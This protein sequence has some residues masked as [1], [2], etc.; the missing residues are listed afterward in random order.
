M[1]KRDSEKPAQTK[2]QP[3][4]TPIDRRDFIKG[5]AI[6]LA[7]V[8][9][10][11]AALFAGDAKA[12]SLSA[13][14]T[15]TE[16]DVYYRDRLPDNQTPFENPIDDAVSL[17]DWDFPK[18]VKSA[19]GDGTFG[20]EGMPASFSTFT[21][22]PDYYRGMPIAI[23][24][25]G[26]AG[27]AAGYELMKLGF[28]PVF[29]EMQTQDSPDGTTYAR[30]FGRIYSWDFGGNGQYDGAGAGWYPTYGDDVASQALNPQ[31]GLNMHPW[32][33]RVAELGGMRFPATHLT[34]RTYTDD[35]FNDDYRYGPE[36]LVSPWVAFRDPGLYVPINPPNPHRG[37]VVPPSD[38]DLLDYDTVYNTKGIFADRTSPNPPEPGGYSQTDRVR[39]GTTL[40]S[41]NAAVRNLTFKYYNLLYGDPDPGDPYQGVLTPILTLYSAY[42][43]DQS[44][45]IADQIVQ[46]WKSLIDK[47]DNKSLREVLSEAGWDDLPAYEGDWGT[48]DISLAEMFG[49]IGT[50]T[51]PFAM[52]YY[53]SF[54][55]LLRIALQAADSN[56]DYFLGG[57]GYQ[58]QPF[59]THET[60]TPLGRTTLWNQTA[61]RVITDKVYQ[62]VDNAG[63]GVLIKTVDS[64]GM[65][66]ERP[67]AAA[68]VTAS[69]SAIRAAN[70]FPEPDGFIPSRAVSYIKRVRINNNSKI[71]LNFPNYSDQPYSSAFWM[72]RTDNTDG[73]PN[74]DLIVTT[75]TDKTIRQ[76]YTFDNYHW[77]TQVSNDV[78]FGGFAQSGTLLL[79]YGWDYN[80]QSWT[81][82]D[83]VDAVKNAWLQM[84]EIYGFS[85]SDYGLYLNWALTNNQYAVIVWEKVDGFNAA[86]RMAQPGRGSEYGD[87]AGNPIERLSEL[88]TVQT[89]GMTGFNPETGKYTGLFLAGEA[90]ASPGLSG[91]VEGSIQTALQAVAGIVRYLNIDSPQ[92]VTPVVDYTDVSF[93]LNAI[94][95]EN[96]LTND[97]GMPR[98]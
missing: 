62:V 31:Y 28:Q 13:I 60:D 49:E 30:P 58:L 93:A 18:L 79:N 76:I 57:A 40:D 78:E 96:P 75:L 1:S 39:A 74:S 80:A 64:K 42:T 50:G 47:Y 20:T 44:D 51:G 12:K 11:K 16:A 83:P 82:A 90:T 63:Y 56:Q 71:A 36:G 21:T 61:G 7:A 35:I 37:G 77:A 84:A 2:T 14:I 94:P 43:E 59:L 3:T 98:K 29:F 91:W 5:S 32:G 19:T 4:D 34:L 26:A 8:T 67:F 97:A 24:G 45:E 95:G 69:P 41:S 70:L 38:G 10:S 33:R 46:E 6:A 73:N 17:Y 66:T 23:I 27:L 92:P 89:F 81:A 54:M 72:N 87:P 68:V 85:A 55:E 53:S 25:A 86:W 65:V 15:K 48:L 88:Q 22:V 9:T 52:F